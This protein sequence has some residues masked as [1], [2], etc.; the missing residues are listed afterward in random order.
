MQ[1]RNLLKKTKRL[2]DKTYGN[3]YS[4]I[5]NDFNCNLC[6]LKLVGVNSLLSHD[7][8]KTHQGRVAHSFTPFVDRFRIGGPIWNTNENR[9]NRTRVNLI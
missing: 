4:R 5:E 2:S 6:S 1:V 7:S 8:N 9:L 3:I